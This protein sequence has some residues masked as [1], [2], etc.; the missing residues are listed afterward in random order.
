MTSHRG[1]ITPAATTPRATCSRKWRRVHPSEYFKRCM[2]SVPPLN[3][4]GPRGMKCLDPSKLR[5]TELAT[6]FKGAGLK[7][8]GRIPRTR[9]ERVSPADSGYLKSAEAIASRE[10]VGNEA[11]S[12][13]AHSC[14]GGDANRAAAMGLALC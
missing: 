4:E 2:P 12:H 5:T 10:R 9:Y 13:G 7:I 8:R 6:R 14:A 1:A 3:S 11:A